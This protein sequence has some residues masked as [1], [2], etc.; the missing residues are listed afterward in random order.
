[1]HPRSIDRRN[2][3]SHIRPPIKN[4]NSGKGNSSTWTNQRKRKK[5]EKEYN[6]IYIWTNNI[7]SMGKSE[8]LYEL[9]EQLMIQDFLE[10]LSEVKKEEKCV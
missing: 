8:K 1:M 5:K 10:V 3:T 6:K 7:K 9:K 4:K 2:P